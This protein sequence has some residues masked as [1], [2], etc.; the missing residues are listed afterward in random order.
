MPPQSVQLIFFAMFKIQRII[1]RTYGTQSYG[2]DLFL[3]IALS[4]VPFCRPKT[5]PKSLRAVR[6]LRSLHPLIALNGLNS[7]R[8]PHGA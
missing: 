1:E 3:C 6:P 5:N 2:V 7:P 8:A 4:I